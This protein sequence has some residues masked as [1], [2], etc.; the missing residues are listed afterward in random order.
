[1]W[2]QCRRVLH[3]S[4]RE[5]RTDHCAVLVYVGRSLRSPVCCLSCVCVGSV[6]GQGRISTFK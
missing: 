3:A 1:M 2:G 6:G 4:D 5:V